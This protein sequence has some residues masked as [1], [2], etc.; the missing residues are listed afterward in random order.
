MRVSFLWFLVVNAQPLD[1]LYQA[2]TS[3]DVLDIMA[4]M[5]QVR[6]IVNHI[7]RNNV[8]INS[9]YGRLSQSAERRP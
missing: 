3:D 6:I 9:A 1:S 4:L 8:T 2:G 5:N 7:S